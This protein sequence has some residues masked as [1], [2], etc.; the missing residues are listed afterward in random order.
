MGCIDGPVGA[1]GG[2]GMSLACGLAVGA[3]ENKSVRWA[4]N[5]G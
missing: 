1:L 5:R 3:D 2:P 4:V